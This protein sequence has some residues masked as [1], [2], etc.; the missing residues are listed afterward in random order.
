MGRPMNRADQV[1]DLS[2][3]SERAKNIAKWLKENGGACFEEQLHL[4]EGSQERTYWHYG[5]MVALADAL[6]FL[7]GESPITTGPYILSRGKDS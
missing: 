2:L 7:T 3:L 4:N 1:Y 5:Y 6:R